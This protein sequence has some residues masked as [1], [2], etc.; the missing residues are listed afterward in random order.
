MAGQV[1]R[2]DAGGLGQLLGEQCR[3]LPLDIIE[4]TAIGL[5]R[6]LQGKKGQGHRF[7]QSGVSTVR[8]LTVEDHFGANAHVEHLVFQPFV[9]HL[10]VADFTQGVDF[11]IV[12]GEDPIGD[13]LGGADP[14]RCLQRGRLAGVF[15]GRLAR[16]E[17][18]TVDD[19]R[20]PLG[21]HLHGQCRQGDCGEG[22][23]QQQANKT[24]HGAQMT[25][26]VGWSMQR[27]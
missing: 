13:L 18:I 9:E 8:A 26:T 20:A 11:Q 14:G 7:S 4:A 22:H 5:G 15:G 2:F 6:L 24:Q 17:Q 23:D 19:R 27:L 10:D 12:H 1:Q 3:Q 25:D 21:D 16:L